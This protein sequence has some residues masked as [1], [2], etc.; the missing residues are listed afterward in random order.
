MQLEGQKLC[1]INAVLTEI[2]AALYRTIPEHA[3]PRGD[4]GVHISTLS[5]IF[6]RRNLHAV[7]RSA[8]KFVRGF[9]R[10]PWLPGA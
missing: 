9:P 7:P 2:K 10:C 3:K 6:N 8:C 4:H 5:C 1:T